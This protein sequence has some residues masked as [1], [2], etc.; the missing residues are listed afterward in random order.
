MASIFPSA[1]SCV[2]GALDPVHILP[3][4]QAD[5]GQDTGDKGVLSVALR[6]HRHG[7]ALQVADGAD[8][9]AR[10]QLEA[11]EVGPRHEYEWVSGVQPSK[12]R[13]NEVRAEVDLA[14]G[15][16]FER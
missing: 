3:G 8:L 4:I 15:C 9:L 12:G 5:I 16:R 11:A 14:G 13:P 2:A 10:K 6:A 1:K 7:L